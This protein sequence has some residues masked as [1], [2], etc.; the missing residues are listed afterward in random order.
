M[1]NTLLY[2]IF[3]TVLNIF[4]LSNGDYVRSPGKGV[5]V[6]AAIKHSLDLKCEYHGDDHD[7]E[8]LEWYRD[9]VS[10]YKEK[11]GHYIIHNTKKESRLTIKIFVE[12]DADIKK[13]S[14]KTKKPGFE[15][16]IECQFGP[17]IIHAAPQGIESDRP[18]EKIDSPH[19]SVRRSQ[20]DRITLKC[21][22]E[23]TRKGKQGVN[24]IKWEFSK[25][26]E[27][28]SKL[29]DSVITSSKDIIIIDRIEKHHRGYYRCSVNDVSSIVLLRVKDRLAA[30]WP[31]L[32]IVGI[33]LVLV[34]IILVFEK[35]ERS[36][37]KPITTDDEENDHANDPLVRSSTKPLD[38]ENKK[39]VA[40]A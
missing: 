7:G 1:A 17:I 15:E 28:Y 13:W 5:Q 25:N 30:L 2:F 21:I 8:F 4:V 37:R 39:R 12:A 24:D 18:D 14:V 23:S 31:F 16:P 33:V 32:G 36:A 3:L 27:T 6:K 26:D 38:D 20:G 9:D 29:P 11:P 22:I 35:R 10:V 34:I 19:G 40:K